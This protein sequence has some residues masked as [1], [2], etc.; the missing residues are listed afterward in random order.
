[1]T[2]HIEIKHKIKNINRK[3]DFN[4]LLEE[5]MLSDIEKEMMR[6]FYV[7]KKTIDIIADELGYTPQGISKMHKRIL[8]QLES[9]L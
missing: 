2:K 9:L 4:N 8:N 5:S 1:M 6:K 7:S 3:A